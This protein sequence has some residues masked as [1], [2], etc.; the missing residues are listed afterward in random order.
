M[1]FVH[2]I[3]VPPIVCFCITA[4]R[5][6][7]ATKLSVLNLSDVA[8]VLNPCRLRPVVQWLRRHYSD[9]FTVSASDSMPNSFG[10][11]ALKVITLPVTGWMN[12]RVSACNASL[13][14]GFVFAPYFLSPAIGH[15]N[16]VAEWTRI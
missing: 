2:F 13:P 9:S 16:S 11:I 1:T 7:T 4:F 12:A 5:A 6:M 3:Y 14:A 15:P 10:G 8:A